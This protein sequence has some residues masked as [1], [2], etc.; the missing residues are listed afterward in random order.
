MNAYRTDVR[1]PGIQISTFDPSTGRGYLSRRGVLGLLGPAFVAAVAFVDPG[2]IATNTSAGASYR[3]LLL[4]TVVSA[5]AVAMVVQY[6][7]AKLG[8]ATGASLAEVCRD[9]TC[10][11]VRLGLWIVA[12]LVVIMTDL[13]ELVGGA[14]ALNL[15]LGMPLVI[16][17]VVVLVATVGVLQL[18]VRG[19]EGF[20][21]VI[22][23]LLALL[24]LAF[25]YLVLRAPFDLQGA[26]GGFV[27]RLGDSQSAL[28]ACGIVGATV[29]PHAVFLHSSLTGGL[30]GGARTAGTPVVLRFLRRDV[31]MAMGVAGGVNVLMLLAAT[32]LPAGTGD[33]LTAAHNGF[34]VQR[35]PVFASVFALALLASGLASACASV[36]SGQAVMQG[37]LRRGSSI[38]VRRAVTAVPALVL[39]AVVT[40]PT[41]ALVLSQVGLSFGLPFALAPLLLFTARRDVMG[42]F[43]NRRV[44]TVVGVVITTLVVVLNAYVLSHVLGAS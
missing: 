22:V 43:V 39:L 27:P 28:L 15:L 33:S 44:T 42:P 19:R 21:A 6:L 41:Q 8:M 24:G 1:P 11:P 5:S 34:A 30:G 2:N 17:G 40:E 35:G 23:G 12:E 36:Y 7:S 38:W 26:V 32:S 4:W 31:V 18:R 13:A 14:L 20:P 3:Y 9:H 10:T 16:G 37:F 25:L 29:M